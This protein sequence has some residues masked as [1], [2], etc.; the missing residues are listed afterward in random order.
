[1]KK[2]FT[3]RDDGFTI[4]YASFRDFTKIQ[5]LV[6]AL[7]VES[8]QFF[9]P[10]LFM[11]NQSLKVKM[12]K[13]LASKSLLP[14]FGTL[15]K[16]FFPYAYLV[17]L[18]VESPDSKLVGYL[19]CYF[20]KKRNDGYYEATTG[21]AMSEKY[22]RKGL[23]TW[24]RSSIFEVARKE[25]VKLLRAGSFSENKQILRIVVDKLGWKV[26]GKRK[27]KSEYDGKIREVVDL[28]KEL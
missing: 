4:S 28:I 26:I 8:K 18:K 7:P 23:G 3:K 21:G 25:R 17:I 15:I 11:E 20:F 9:S 16:K 2:V 19:A 14:I 6:N 12:G 1:M 24:I 5:Q 22:G 13:F 27:V 10:W